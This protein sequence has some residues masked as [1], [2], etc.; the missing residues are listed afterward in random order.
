VTL[1]CN[2]TYYFSTG[3]LLGSPFADISA[4]ICWQSDAGTFIS[5]SST[6]LANSVGETLQTDVWTMAS[7]T[8]IPSYNCTSTFYFSDP[9][10]RGPYRTVAQNSVSWMC[11]SE[12]AKT[13]C[14]YVYL[15]LKQ[16]WFQFQKRVTT[17][18]VCPHI[19]KRLNHRHTST[20][21]LS[22]AHF[23]SIFHVGL[24]CIL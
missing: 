3:A 24:R 18:F 1:T 9:V 13:W 20:V 21:F 10:Q 22:E 6:A 2:M 12:P 5:N 17:A 11:A 8:E 4:S 23:C 14:T 19:K 16:N 15:L 7:G